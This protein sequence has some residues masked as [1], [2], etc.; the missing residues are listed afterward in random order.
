MPRWLHRLQRQLKY[1]LIR[2][3]KVLDRFTG[4]NAKASSYRSD[5]YDAVRE[6]S[7]LIKQIISLIDG[8]SQEADN[9]VG[10]NWALIRD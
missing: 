6:P 2:L 4:L 3:H 5:K 9:L 8:R 1:L 10:W 7:R